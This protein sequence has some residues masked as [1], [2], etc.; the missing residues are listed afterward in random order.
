MMSE[1]L[2]M[3]EAATLYYDKKLT[4]QEIAGRMNL[5]RQTVSKL[6]SDAVRENIVEIKIHHPEETRTALE[7]QLCDTF[8]IRR[9]VV[10][11]V[12]SDDETMCRMM[13]VRAA[14]DYILPLVQRGGLN[15]AVSWGR[16]VQE[17]IHT[18]P[19]THTKGNTVFPLLG[20]TNNEK[21]YFSSNELA[22][23]LADKLDAEVK[24]AWFPYMPDSAADYRL[25]KQLSY[26]EKMQAMWDAAD[27]SILG[28]GSKKILEVFGETFGYSEIHS[29]AI[30]DI[31]T[32]FFD[33]NGRFV[34]LYENTLCA[35]ADSIRNAKESIAIA[36]GK[37]KTEAII[38]AL[39]TKLIDTLITD[40]YTAKRV[41]ECC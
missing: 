7:T 4:Q 39:R 12:S 31:A 2:L 37:E 24:H 15:I 25:L 23:N 14:V 5:S 18:L 28:I 1:K 16:T 38:G 35:S 9:C 8:G 30:G 11:S 20:A 19:E 10:C 21:S 22:R 27:L 36:C 32:H 26:Y 34:D 17:L 3:Y 41:L 33:E 13:T 6:L 29:Q 40:E